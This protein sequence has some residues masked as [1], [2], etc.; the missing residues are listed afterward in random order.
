M[1]MPALPVQDPDAIYPIVLMGVIDMPL[2]LTVRTMC[3]ELQKR[4]S[5][6]MNADGRN[7]TP[8]LHDEMASGEFI[9]PFIIEGGP[10]FP[11]A[12]VSRGR[13]VSRPG[14]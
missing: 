8:G 1:T 12:G 6:V 10:N 3:L 5:R 13:K 7:A 9:S 14:A 2:G 11:R 4:W